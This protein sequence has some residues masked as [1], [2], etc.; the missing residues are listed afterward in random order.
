RGD[1][2]TRWVVQT[3]F[4]NDEAV[5][6]LAER[7]HRLG[8]EERLAKTMPKRRRGP[9]RTGGGLRGLRLG[10]FLGRRGRPDRPAWHRHPAGL[11]R[12]GTHHFSPAVPVFKA[13]ARRPVATPRMES[14]LH[15]AEHE[16]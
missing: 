7:L 11:S 10:P 14:L 3:D 8:I 16:Q 12:A 1:K 15:G 9:H 13:R 2:P 6:Y 4:S 5:G